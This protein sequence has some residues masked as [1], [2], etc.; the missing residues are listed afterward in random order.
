M[1]RAALPVCRQLGVVRALVTCDVANIGSRKVIEASGGV[2]E[3]ERGGKLRY[4]IRTG[5]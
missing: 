5:N 4:W 1:L 3:D 2:F